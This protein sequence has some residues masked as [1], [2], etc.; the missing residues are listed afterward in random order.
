MTCLHFQLRRSVRSSS[1]SLISSAVVA[2][3]NC[4]NDLSWSVIAWSKPWSSVQSKISGKFFEAALNVWEIKMKQPLSYFP[5]WWH[6]ISRASISWLTDTIVTG[7]EV[8]FH[9]SIHVK[10]RG[11]QRCNA[12]QSQEKTVDCM[13]AEITWLIWL[14]SA[15][16]IFWSHWHVTHAAAH[17]KLAAYGSFPV[18]CKT[19]WPKLNRVKKVLCYTCSAEEWPIR[20]AIFPYR[21]T[22]TIEPEYLIIH[23]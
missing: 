6:L 9:W 21:E 2:I 4:S 19:W 17:E 8:Y 20:F 16:Y 3:I 12:R 13:K 11:L 22:I 15:A 14:A 18:V 10:G 1:F 7:V 5:E 23:G